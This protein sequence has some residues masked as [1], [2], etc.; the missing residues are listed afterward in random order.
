MN[1]LQIT[2][3]IILILIGLYLAFFKSYFTEKGKNL[4]TKEDIGE[5]TH[6]IETIKNEI[7]IHSQKKLTY[8]FDRKK[9]AID[10]LNSISV[11]LDYAMR[12]LNILSNNNTDKKIISGLIS[13][14]KIKGANATKDFWCIF[15]YFE[16][17]RITSVVDELYSKCVELNNHT[18]M[19]LV[20]V[21]RKAVE[22]EYNTT[23]LRQSNNPIH[24]EEARTELNKI[25]QDI[26]EIISKYSKEK[27]EVESKAINL[28]LKYTVFLGELL[29][30]DMTNKQETTNP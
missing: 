3:D 17:K 27:G 1:N 30:E 15:I 22:Y 6:E 26:T 11:W 13:D 10:F 18:N 8:Y 20:T 21:E 29:K 16:D 2:F 9:S 19:M 12:P 4:A 5:I 7:G 23:K 24:I 28:R 14:L 25:N